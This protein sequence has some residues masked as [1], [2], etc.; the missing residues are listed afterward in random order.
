[1]ERGLPR[2]LRD[3]APT[4]LLSGLPL[5]IPAQSIDEGFSE[6]QRLIGR[7]AAVRG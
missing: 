2:P 1:M 4:L 6:T 5:A 7:V 3:S